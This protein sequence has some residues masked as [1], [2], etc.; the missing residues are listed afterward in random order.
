MKCPLNRDGVERQSEMPNDK[1]LHSAFLIGLLTLF[2]FISGASAATST[3]NL[4]GLTLGLDEESGSILYLA[5]PEVGVILQ[6]SQQSA[7]L[8]DIA[9]PVD[10]FVPLR[11][12]SRFSKARIVRAGDAITVTWDPLAP[13]RRNFP[14]PSGKIV[15]QVGIRPAADG[16]SVILTCRVENQS[17]ASVPQVMFP[18]LWGL[19]PF[20]GLE[21]TRLRLPRGQVWPFT[22]PIRAPDSATFYVGR[23]W[24]GYPPAGYYGLNALRWLDYGSLRGGLSV[25]QKK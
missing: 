17:S 22:E 14:M 24:K 19:Q 9:Y 20:D 15:A 11:L 18:D 4:N 16:K 5:Y 23:G 7:G 3:I 10:A 8:L 2:G 12:A 21:Q 13:S 25:F 1:T 6:A